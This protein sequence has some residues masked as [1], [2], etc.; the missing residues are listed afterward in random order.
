M[1]TAISTVVDVVIGIAGQD[2]PEL[3]EA[4]NNLEEV[5]QQAFEPPS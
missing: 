4:V 2:V 1:A 5:L 3:D